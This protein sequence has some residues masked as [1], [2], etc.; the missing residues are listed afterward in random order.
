MFF[1]LNKKLSKNDIIMCI[2]TLANMINVIFNCKRNILPTIIT[3][4]LIAI[5]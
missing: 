4:I 2:L 3:L 1:L 5:L